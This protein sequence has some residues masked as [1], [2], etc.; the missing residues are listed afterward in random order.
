MNFPILVQITVFTTFFSPA[1]PDDYDWST[2]YPIIKNTESEG[3]EFLDVGCGY[4]GL[5]GKNNK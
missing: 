2:L 3:I 1:H 5:L 4:G